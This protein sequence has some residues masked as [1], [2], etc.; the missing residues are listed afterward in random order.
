MSTYRLG[1]WFREVNGDIPG[2][3]FCHVYVK[4]PLSYDYDDAKDV[5]FLTPREFGPQ[6]IENQIDALIAELK[7][8]KTEVRRRY[9]EYDRKLKAQ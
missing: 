3:P 1:L 4:E 9:R 6:V 2:R 7:E 5:I 8:I